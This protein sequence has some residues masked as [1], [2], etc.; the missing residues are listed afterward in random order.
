M[1]SPLRA[2]ELAFR[3][4]LVQ[5]YGDQRFTLQD[6]WR[7]RPGSYAWPYLWE[8]FPAADRRWPEPAWGERMRR[9]LE[10]LSGIEPAPG[11]RG[12][13]GWRV[14]PAVVDRLAREREAVRTARNAPHHAAAAA[15]SS[16]F[17]TITLDEAAQRV[18]AAYPALD[19][20]PRRDCSLQRPL[21]MGMFIQDTVGAVIHD[22]VRTRRYA[23]IAIHGETGR[24]S[25]AWEHAGK[26]AR[27]LA[28]LDEV[29]A[30]RIEAAARHHEARLAALAPHRMAGAAPPTIPAGVRRGRSAQAHRAEPTSTVMQR[31]PDQVHRYAPKHE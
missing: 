23:G 2:H 19:L 25:C 5:L 14:A 30:R 9:E 8:R 17:A 24:I 31:E 15:L 22:W 18:Q 6:L 7:E 26:L 10:R 4:A 27:V 20:L 1:S 28:Q 3:N 29:V 12:G 11:P 16:R 21:L 13:E